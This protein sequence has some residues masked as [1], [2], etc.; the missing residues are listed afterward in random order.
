MPCV[1]VDCA[2]LTRRRCSGGRHRPRCQRG[3]VLR[4]AGAAWFGED[5]HHR[6]L[7]RAARTRL[8]HGTSFWGSSGRATNIA[9]GSGW[10]YSFRRRSSPT[11][12]R[13]KRH[14]HIFAA[15]PRAARLSRTFIGIVQVRWKIFFF[16]GQLSGGQKQR[17][18]IACALVGDPNLLF[19]S[20]RPPASIRKRA[21]RSGSSSSNSKRKAAP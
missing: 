11:S 9:C 7:R 15:S 14:L 1:C 2:R 17:L 10:A 8:R 5:Y 13:S 6:D 12:S 16:V 21:A 19:L 18:A 4:A 3:R 20:S